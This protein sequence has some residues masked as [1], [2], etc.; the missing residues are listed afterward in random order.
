MSKRICLVIAA[1]AAL[2]SFAIW[3]PAEDWPVMRTYDG[4]HLYR[5][6]LPLG[7][8]GTG[9]VSLGGRGDLVEWQLMNIPAKQYS[10]IRAGNDALG[11][12]VSLTAGHSQTFEL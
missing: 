12:A 8:I 1:F 4:A 9:S 6:A 7:G 3:R 2:T 11:T 10:T 5:I